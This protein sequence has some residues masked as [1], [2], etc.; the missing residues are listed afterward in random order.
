MFY[1]HICWILILKE[2]VNNSI[3]MMYFYS[4]SD[5]WLFWTD[6]PFPP[7][8]R[9]CIE[10]DR[11]HITIAWEPPENDRGN[12]V[13]GYIVE[14]KELKSNRWTPINRGL[15]PVR[16]QPMIRIPNPGLCNCTTRN[17][18]QFVVFSRTVSLRMRRLQKGRNMNTESWQSMRLETLNP[19][20]RVNLSLPNLQKVRD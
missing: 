19:A 16:H 11:D 20:F 4:L 7:S 12:P 9:K 2:Q 13:Q 14:R 3:S 10:Q 5:Y 15:V 8:Q 1:F 18:F 17:F 6:E